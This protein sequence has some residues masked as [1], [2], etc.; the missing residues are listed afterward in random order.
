MSDK[1]ELKVDGQVITHFTSYRIDADLYTPADAFHLELSNPETDVKPGKLCEILIN[2]QKELTGVIDK[3][4][5]KVT[6]NGVTLSVE[7]RDFMGL[8]LDSYCDTPMTI[9]NMKLQ[10]LAEKLLAKVPFIKV[11]DIRY[12]ENVVGKLK[13]K[14]SQTGFL[15]GLDI[16]HKKGQIEWGMTIFEVLKNYALSRGM[17]FYCNPD[18]ILVFGRPMATGAPEY[19]VTML[20]NGRGNNV[21]ESDYTHDISHQYSKIIIIGQQ[22]G[23]ETVAL[24]SINKR[25]ERTIN[26]FPFYKPFVSID[27]NDNVSQEERARLIAEKQHRDAKKMSY[28]VGR[29]NQNNKNW[30]IN[31]F[32]RVKDEVQNID[33]E[34]LIYGRIFELNKQ[35]GPTTRIRIGEPGEIA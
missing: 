13:S 16:T 22:Q 25:T 1:V 17:L 32:C 4:N 11:D 27:N 19:S 21:I 26:D 6:K 3:I 24:A 15:S 12:Q 14:T 9:K 2:G 33:G 8:L 30:K 18:G 29:H 35:S 10:T 20:K 34:Y 28:M 31:K 23:A 7:G 5:R